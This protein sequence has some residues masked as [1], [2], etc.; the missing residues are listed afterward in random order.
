MNAGETPPDAAPARVT[1]SQELG[2]LAVQF[3]GRPVTL[4]EILAATKGRGF[5]L[6][7]LFIALPF[8]TPI[9][10]P[11]VSIPFGMVIAIIGA[12]LALGREPWLPKR[13][14]NREL[15]PR[16]LNGVLTAGG[17][18]LRFLEKFLRPRLLF[19]HEHFIY[20]HLAGLF[21]TVSGLF[22][23][24]PLPVPFSNGLPAWAVVFL[25]AAALERDGVCF[26]LGCIMF[27]L[28][29][30]FFVLL[31]LGGGE[32]IDQIRKAIT[33][34]GPSLGDWLANAAVVGP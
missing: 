5:N 32:L 28:A 11:G 21:I 17:R 6:L 33:V 26:V 31:A 9:P 14:L 24:L 12:R 13:L 30:A 4:A 20:R 2:E 22:M 3:A 34:A 25:A 16:L 19:I 15:P 23:L 7:L 18:V 27:G 29:C 10:T 1:F 8:I